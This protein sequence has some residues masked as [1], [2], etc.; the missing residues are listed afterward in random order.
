MP[1]N[2]IHH[3]GEILSNKASNSINENPDI[4]NLNKMENSNEDLEN[5]LKKLKKI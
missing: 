2:Q 4:L 5:R 1:N 3:D